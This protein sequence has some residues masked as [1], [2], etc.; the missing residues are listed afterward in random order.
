M[1][2]PLLVNLVDAAWGFPPTHAGTG[3]DTLV[4]VL[5]LGACVARARARRCGGRQAGRQ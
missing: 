2:N 1:S 4:L 3:V 5:V